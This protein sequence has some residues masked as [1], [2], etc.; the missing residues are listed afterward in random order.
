MIW[1]FIKSN[2]FSIALVLLLVMA[3]ARRGLRIIPGGADGRPQQELT[4]G[5]TERFTEKETAD[6]AKP[7]TLD[8]GLADGRSREALPNIDQATAVA[9]LRRFGNAVV[10]EQKKFHVPASVLLAL[11]YVNSYS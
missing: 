1:R 8:L 6:A 2:W 4:R 7:S 9:F 10:G 11:S 3:V 5:K